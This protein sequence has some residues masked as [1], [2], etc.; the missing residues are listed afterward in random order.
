MLGGDAAIPD[1]AGEKSSSIGF[2]NLQLAQAMGD[3]QALIHRDRR[4]IRVHFSKDAVEGI[5]DLIQALK[6]SGD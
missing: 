6:K 4:V 2:K 1:V 3:Y 5:K